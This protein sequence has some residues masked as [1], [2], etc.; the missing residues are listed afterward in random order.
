MNKP[1][2]KR[3][4]DM[5]IRRMGSTDEDYVRNRTVIANA[6]VGQMLPNGAVKGGS[7]L[8]MRFGD[9]QTRATTDLD[10]ARAT[11]QDSFV[12]EFA[13]NL[14]IGWE[15]FTARLVEMPKAH[16][17]DVPQAYVMQP[18]E[19][20]LSYLG[21]SWCTVA[22]ELAHNEIGDAD[23]ADLVVPADAS[24]MLASMGFAELKPVPVMPL[25]YQIAQK[26]HAASEPDSQRAHDLV[27]L[28]LM[29]ANAEVDYTQ[30]KMVCERL[31]AYRRKHAW[32]PELAANPGWDTVYAEAAKGLDVAQDVT[33]AV[34]WTN[35]LIERIDQGG[36]NR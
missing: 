32:P 17:K 11:D 12:N 3:N 16:P 19:V 4:L 5:A 9:K 18:Y 13:R 23:V 15:G 29:V 21:A 8:K 14:R 26:L 34:A 25:R 10:A 35:D 1:N 36:S 30:T 2:S 24:A 28:Q 31:F 7:S 6:V 20:K 33:D 22:F 27:D